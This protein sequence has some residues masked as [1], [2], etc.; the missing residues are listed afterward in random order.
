M[1]N[2]Y[3]DAIDFEILNFL[4][5]DGRMSLTEMADKLN[6]AVNTVRTRLNRML[7]DKTLQIIG[8]IDPAKVGFH[9]YVHIFIGI[10]P[11][12]RLD[13]VAAQIAQMPE[14]SFLAMISGNY[15]L[16][17]NVMCK[18][19][20]HLLEVLQKIQRIEGV[21]DSA[22]SSYYKIFKI[23]QPDLSILKEYA[24]IEKQT[25]PPVKL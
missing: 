22:T 19:N 25:T 24:P 9:A 4:Q 10:R 16:E 23:S 7:E 3:L 5:K 12:N 2:E 14:V 13:E 18:N 8:R 15:D 17:V 21:Y 1:Q 11:A 6:V 20:A